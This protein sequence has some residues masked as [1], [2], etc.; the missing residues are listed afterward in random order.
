MALEIPKAA[1][2]DAEVGADPAK[3]LLLERFGLGQERRISKC[4][5][6]LYTCLP[7]TNTLI[8]E[9]GSALITTAGEGSGVCIFHRMNSR[10]FIPGVVSRTDL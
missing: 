4:L 8:L 2:R 7:P 6:S 9:G 3:L 5:I 10:V 1:K